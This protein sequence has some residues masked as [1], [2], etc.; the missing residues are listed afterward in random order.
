MTQLLLISLEVLYSSEAL[1][2]AALRC[3]PM[4]PNEF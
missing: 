4:A 1:L 3:S 2:F